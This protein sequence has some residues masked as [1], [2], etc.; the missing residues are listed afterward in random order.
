[1]PDAL[2]LILRSLAK[3]CCKVVDVQMLSLHNAFSFLTNHCSTSSVNFQELLPQLAY[4][5]LTCPS[6]A[7]KEL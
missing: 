4:L 6:L 3:A 1:M 5:V 7:E 2:T